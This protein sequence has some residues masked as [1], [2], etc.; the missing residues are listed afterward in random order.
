MIEKTKEQIWADLVAVQRGGNFHVTP[1]ESQLKAATAHLRH[2]GRLAAAVSIAAFLCSPF[3]ASATPI[4]GSD[5]DLADFAVLA[6]TP[7]VTNVPTSTIYGD[8]GSTSTAFANG[9]GYTFPTPP[10]GSIQAD[11]GLAI[12]AQADLTAAITYLNGLPSSVLGSTALGAGGI[13]SLG[14]GIYTGAISVTGAFTLQGNGTPNDTWVFVTD[15]LTFNVGSSVSINDAGSDPSVYWVDASSVTID[16]GV[17]DPTTL[18][19]NILALTSITVGADA[20]DA[21]GRLLAETGDVTLISNTIGNDC[22]A[23]GLNSNGLAG[24]SSGG[25]TPIPEPWSLALFG[26]GLLGL[27]GLAVQQRRVPLPQGS[28]RKIG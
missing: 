27:L 2:G 19:G 3:P 4:L 8:L 28:R 13:T 18:L 24:G 25:T 1:G 16:S 20:T 7:G 17:S 15:G 21:C 26:G 22:T 23:L 5:G 9:S 6:G 14:P 12:G 10:S 11:T